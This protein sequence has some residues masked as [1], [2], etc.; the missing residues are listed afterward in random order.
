MKSKA[1]GA[2]KT[3]LAICLLALPMLKPSLLGFAQT[4]VTLALVINGANLLALYKNFRTIFNEAMAAAV[5]Q[6]DKIA[7]SVPS[8]TAIES[9][10]WMGAFPKMREW[11]GDRQISNL[12]AYDWT[13]KNKDWETTVAVPRNSIEDDQYGVFSPIIRSMGAAA[14]IHPDD[15]V[16]ALLANGFTGKGYDGKTFF[17]TDHASGS[18]KASGGGS[19]FSV[20]SYEAAIAAIRAIKDDKGNALFS[21]TEQLTLVVPPALEGAAKRLLNADFISVSGGSTENNIWKGSANLIVSPKLT[22][23][24]AWFILVDF[25]GLR[26]LIYQQRKEPEF[27]AK[28]DPTSSDHVFMRKEFLYGADSRDNAGY[29]LHQLAYGSVGA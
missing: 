20:T 21:G 10:N 6:W 28:E 5:P 24:T 11:I 13:I 22:S 7:M 18:N 23:A 4:G 15:I 1:F 8:G 19:A 14:V 26:P 16:F 2:L 3:I 29:G 9:Y 17:A 25:M 12:K 27:V